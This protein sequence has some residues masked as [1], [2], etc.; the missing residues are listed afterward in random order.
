MISTPSTNIDS[1]WHRFRSIYFTSHDTLDNG[2][3]GVNRAT[4]LCSPKWILELKTLSLD[5]MLQQSI[6]IKTRDKM[7]VIV[8]SI[9]R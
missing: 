1:H 9:A 8:A 2:R 6:D 7:H 3:E 4:D 5:F